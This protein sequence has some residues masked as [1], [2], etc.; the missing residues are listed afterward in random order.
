MEFSSFLSMYWLAWVTSSLFS[1]IPGTYS[2]TSADHY[3]R[4]AQGW[5]H[6]TRTKVAGSSALLGVAS[7][8]PKIHKIYTEV[9]PRD[10]NRL[11]LHSGKKLQL[12]AHVVF[13]TYK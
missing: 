6:T 7:D 11:Q 10:F 9:R 2:A 13:Y 4:L 5:V 3:D 1:P 8:R 12:A